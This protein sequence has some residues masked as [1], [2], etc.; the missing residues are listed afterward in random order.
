MRKKIKNM[1]IKNMIIKNKKYDY[2]N[3]IKI[4]L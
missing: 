4:W 2:K 3:I 1:I